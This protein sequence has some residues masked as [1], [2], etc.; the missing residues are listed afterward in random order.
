[1]SSPFYEFQL[2]VLATFCV[3]AVAFERRVKGDPDA[4][5]SSHSKSDSTSNISGI[6]NGNG[7]SGPKP[8]ASSTAALARNYLIVYGIVMCEHYLD[9][10]VRTDRTDD[11]S[12]QAL[13]GF[14][15]HTCTLSTESSMA[16]Q[17]ALSRRCS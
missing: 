17:N 1:M 11:G 9:L 5:A 13:T 14:K 12:L 8:S 10:R 2:F 6:E 16:T 15:D 4:S 3:A 7:H